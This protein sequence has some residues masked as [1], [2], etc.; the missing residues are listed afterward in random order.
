M[1]PS[2]ARAQ[3]L[4]LQKGW[5]FKIG[6]SPQWAA[7]GLNDQDWAAIDVTH[8]WERQGYPNYDI[9][10]GH[11]EISRAAFMV[12]ESSPSPPTMPLCY[13]INPM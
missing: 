2:F 1:S 8:P 3:H 13:G 7:P 11:R 4:S 10:T 12:R 6:D 5:K 9:N